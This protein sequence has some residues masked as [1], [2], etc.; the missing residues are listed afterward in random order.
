MKFLNII[1]LTLVGFCV[2]AGVAPARACALSGMSGDCD[3]ACSTIEPGWRH[4]T[5]II[6][7]TPP[8]EDAPAR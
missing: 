1:S 7:A 6:G 2:V 4:T 5:C 3:E 8:A